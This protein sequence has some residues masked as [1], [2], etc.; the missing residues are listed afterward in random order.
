MEVHSGDVADET[1]NSSCVN[2][3]NSTISTSRNVGSPTT[4]ETVTENPSSVHFA[5]N[6]SKHEHDDS[7]ELDGGLTNL[8]GSYKGSSE[9]SL[10]EV[11]TADIC[12]KVRVE[13]GYK[14]TKC[15]QCPTVNSKIFVCC[16]SE[17]TLFK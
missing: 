16:Y 3:A 13:T 12:L 4:I 10:S 17:E 11:E 6:S 8:G 14:P 1:E 2:E 7:V 5:N 15:D 9:E